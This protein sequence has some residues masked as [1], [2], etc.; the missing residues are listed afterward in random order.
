MDGFSGDC[1]PLL[2]EPIY[3]E[4]DVM[5][6]SAC[7]REARAAAPYEPSLGEVLNDPVVR[8]VMRADGVHPNELAGILGISFRGGSFADTGDP[9][10]IGSP[11]AGMA[12]PA[13]SRPDR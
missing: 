5:K 12:I 11:A 13:S 7:R 3:K 1:R 6:M 10:E 4:R 2:F 9:T 8:A